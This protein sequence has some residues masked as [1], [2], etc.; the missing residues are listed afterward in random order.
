MSKERNI[1]ETLE[2]DNRNYLGRNE[3]C[4]CNENQNNNSSRYLTVANEEV[5]PQTFE[6]NECNRNTCCC[7]RALRRSLDIL[8]NPLIRSLIDLSSFTLVGNNFNT[9]DGATTLKTVSNCSDG[10]VTYS[11]SNPLFNSTTICD[12]VLVAFSLQPDDGNNCFQGFNR[13]RFIRAI[14][15]CIPPINPR[16]L[17]CVEDVVIQVKHYS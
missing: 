8:L 7:K 14:T 6:R 12:L 17:C 9:E 10:L 1:R 11:D 13:D 16:S 5:L 4:R 15:R 3:D 2:M